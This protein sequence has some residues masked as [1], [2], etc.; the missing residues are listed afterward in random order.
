MSV[1][2]SNVIYLSVNTQRL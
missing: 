2:Y 1:D